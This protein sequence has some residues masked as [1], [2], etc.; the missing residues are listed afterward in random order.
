MIFAV[1]LPGELKTAMAPMRRVLLPVLAISS[2]YNVLLLSGSFF[3]L[4]VYD[5]VL[6]SRSVPSLVSLLMLVALAYAFQAVFDVVRGRIMVH[7]GSLFMRSVSDRVLHVISRYEMSRG[8]MPNG[9]QIVRDVDTV[10]AYLS[11]PGPLAVLDLPWIVVYLLI[12][13]V[14]HWAL[15][16]LALCGVCVLVSLML[17]NNRM[18][19]PLALETMRTGARRTGLA[20]AT[21]RNAETLKALGMAGARRGQW[22]AAEAEYLRANDRF[23]YIASTMSGS[24]KAF[25]MLLQSATLALGAFLVIRG[26]ATGGIII[27]SSILSSRALAPVEQVIANWKGMVSSRQ[28]LARL[29]ELLAAVPF[30]IEPMGLECPRSELAVAG[31]TAA[32]PGTRSIALTDIGFRLEAGD[33]AAVVGRSGS[34]KTTLARVVC[35]IWPALRGS[36]RLDGATLD[37]WSPDQIARIVGYVPQS[38]ELFEGTI[39]QNIA[40]FRPDADREAI[41]KAARAADCHDL[42]VRLDGGYDY[43]IGPQGGGLSA[44]QRQRIALARALFGDPF[45]VVLDEPNSNL[46]YEGETAL[47]LAIRH[48]RERGGIVLVIAHLPSVVAHVSHIMVMANGRIERMETREAFQERMRSPAP[49]TRRDEAPAARDGPSRDGHRDVPDGARDDMAVPAE[50]GE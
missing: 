47:G 31:V 15:G 46:D 20:D 6:P 18:T 32:P 4:L 9:T 37:Q 33:A 7:V 45:L 26:S 28:A 44:G 13:S 36:V 11:G 25:R 12:L 43:L 27:A 35:G 34:G 14:F 40:R 48:V 42:I 17:L 16:L 8:P 50:V 30:R 2:V 5:D 49:I 22:H 23:S 10:R 38:I 3:M 41:L 21:L 39:G 19:A 24:I 29:R 1:R